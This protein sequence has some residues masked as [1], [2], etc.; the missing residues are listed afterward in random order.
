MKEISNMLTTIPTI[1][2]WKLLKRLGESTKTSIARALDP[3]DHKMQRIDRMIEAFH[4]RSNVDHEYLVFMLNQ[5]TKSWIDKH[6]TTGEHSPRRV[7]A[8]KSLF[9]LTQSWLEEMHEVRGPA[10]NW[11]RSLEGALSAQ[12]EREVSPEKA[13]SD[14]ALLDGLGD[15]GLPYLNQKERKSYKIYFKHG[16]AYK[17]VYGKSGMKAKKIDTEVYEP[18]LQIEPLFA[19]DRLGHI[20]SYVKR[21]TDIDKLEQW[22]HSSFLQGGPVMAAGMLMIENGQIRGVSPDSGHYAPGV[23]QMRSVVEQLR[24]Q[25]VRLNLVT[26]YLFQFDANGA[27][28]IIPESYGLYDFEKVRADR[29]LAEYR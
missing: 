18:H 23:R 5:T 4:S 17:K 24:I 13:I 19:M 22:H 1:S 15:V 3:R 29:F 21:P 28:K 9:D 16:L 20:Y 12:F 11:A 10:W 14:Q 26:V 2:Q 8:V 25:M 27:P 7:Q 6:E